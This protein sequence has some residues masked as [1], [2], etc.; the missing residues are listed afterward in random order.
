M[1]PSTFAPH[2]QHGQFRNRIPVVPSANPRS[3]V[4]T[5]WSLA[6]GPWS[7][8]PDP[9]LLVQPPR[10]P[11]DSLGGSRGERILRGDWPQWTDGSYYPCGLAVPVAARNDGRRAARQQGETIFPRTP[12]GPA[13]PPPESWRTSRQGWSRHR[14]FRRKGNPGGPSV[15]RPLVL[16]RRAAGVD[17]AAAPAYHGRSR[18]ARRARRPLRGTPEETHGQA[19]TSQEDRLQEASRAP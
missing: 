5:S 4:P 10:F 19:Q 14:V 17:R 1:R 13:R 7:L 8:F 3:L 15:V 2:L 18:S 11:A 9:L 6:L 16:R 12:V